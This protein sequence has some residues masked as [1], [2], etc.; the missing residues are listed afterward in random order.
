MRGQ[1]IQPSRQVALDARAVVTRAEVMKVTIGVKGRFHAFDLARELNRYGYLRRLITT[2]PIPQA[3]KFGIPRELINSIPF[4]EI[5]D[6]LYGM[7][8]ASVRKR[9]NDQFAIAEWVDRLVERRLPRDTD[10]FVGWSSF[11]LRAIHRAKAYGAKT[12]LERGSSHIEFQRDILQEEYRMFGHDVDPTHP[13]V[14]EK[15][16]EEYQTADYISVPSEFV[17]RTFLDKGIPAEKLI[18]VPYGVSL[19]S[20]QRV[21]KTDDVFRV[22]HC[23]GI[24]LRK[25]VH[26]LLRAFRE[27]DLPNSELRL[28]GSVAEEMRPILSHYSADNVVIAG[29]FPQEELYRHYSQGSVFCLASIEEG[30]A[31]VVAQAMACGLPVICTTNTGGADIL[32]DGV[33]GFVVPIRNVQ[34]L[35]EKLVLMYENHN[36]RREMGANATARVHSG[37]SWSDYG[38]RAIA[39]YEVILSGAPAPEKQPK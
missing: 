11:S 14:V 5:A 37:F 30:L 7:L 19:Q 33:D 34:T 31:M 39:A 32:R 22:I 27:L 6:R 2:Y 18:K 29:P 9:Y 8:P 4:P 3:R 10:I 15:E 36:L 1:R 23:G 17:R 20:F 35:K 26:Y 38:Q 16:L 21:P 13:R 28:I 25:G 12:I 24:S